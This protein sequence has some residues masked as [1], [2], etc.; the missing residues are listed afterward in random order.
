MAHLF[1]KFSPAH[2]YPIFTKIILTAFLFAGCGGGGGG[3]S[4]YE[5]LP[6]KTLSWSPPTSYSDG[7]LL[8][9]SSELDRYE[10]FV[11]ETGTFSDTDQELAAV[12]AVDGASTRATTSFDLA[13]LSPFISKGI[14]YFVSIRAVAKNGLKS[15]FSPSA[16]F[17]Y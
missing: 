6:T 8:N 5:L 4:A 14:Q 2:T 10:I 9:P 3:E 17:S 11:N 1:R 15:D 12:S 16:S 13:N 7:T